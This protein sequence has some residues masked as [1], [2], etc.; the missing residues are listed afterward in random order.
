MVGAAVDHDDVVAERRGQ[1]RG[2][3]VRQ[4]E[5]DDVVA[6]ERLRVGLAQHPVGERHQVWL[7]V[8]QERARAAARR[9]RADLHFRM[10]EQESQQLTPGIAAG[11]GHRDPHHAHDYAR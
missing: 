3:P 2:V 10:S 8:T 6:R 5:E 9:Q 4:R 11:S 1:L 7:V